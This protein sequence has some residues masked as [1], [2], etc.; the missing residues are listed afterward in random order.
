MAVAETAGPATS[1]TGPAP[2]TAQV[3]APG[4]YTSVVTQWHKQAKFVPEEILWES[5]GD[6]GVGVLPDP[7]CS[8][9]C[10]HHCALPT[11]ALP[12]PVSV[13][14][15]LLQEQSCG[16]ADAGST[17]VGHDFGAPSKC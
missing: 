11:L 6:Q 14:W 10:C 4:C 13:R 8:C 5:C 15:L 9:C 16:A 17:G 1:S 2:A 3:S 7:R 12:T